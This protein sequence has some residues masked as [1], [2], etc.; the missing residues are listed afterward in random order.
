MFMVLSSCCH[1]TARVH[2][3]SRDE[4]R[5]SAR[6]PPTL[7][8][9]QPTWAVSPPVGCY[10]LHPPSPFYYYSLLSPKADT[11]FTVPQR[12]EGW[13]DLGTAGKVLQPMPKTA[14]CSDCRDKRTDGSSHPQPGMPALD[15]CTLLGQVGVRNLARVTT[16]QHGLG[17]ELMTIESQVERPSH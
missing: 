12:V 13:V 16:Q 11:H 10:H 9:S 2:P 1:S 4:C 3:G 5:L 15:Y 7:R 17:I 8:P 14:Y 6:W